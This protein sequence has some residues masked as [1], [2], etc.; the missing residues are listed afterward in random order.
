ME[1]LDNTPHK[2]HEP[3]SRIVLT[4]DEIVLRG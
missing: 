2:P 3:G 4:S 1:R